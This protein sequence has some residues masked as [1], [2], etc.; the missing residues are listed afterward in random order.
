MG[1]S[2]T[3]FWKRLAPARNAEVLEVKIAGALA[4]RIV[5][6]GVLII[7]GLEKAMD[8]TATVVAVQ[9]Y[10]ILSP[11]LASWVGT[12][13]GFI[14]LVLGLGV[15]FG[16]IRAAPWLAS[17]LFLGFLAAQLSAIARGIAAPCGCGVVK[18]FA[19]GLAEADGVIGVESVVM[20]SI[21]FLMSAACCVASQKTRSGSEESGA[22]HRSLACVR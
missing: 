11:F 21:L 1:I 10:E 14:E 13:L 15:I 16:T 18:E 8:P 12:S 7:A 6:G 2:Q 19:S 20:T 5:V 3:S 9:E 22:D 4:L 17:L